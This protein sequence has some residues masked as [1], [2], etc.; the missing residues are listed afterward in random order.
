MPHRVPPKVVVARRLCDVLTEYE[1]VFDPSSCQPLLSA[2]AM[3]TGLIQ[4]RLA[5][6]NGI[7]GTFSISSFSLQG[8]FQY[9]WYLASR[10]CNNWKEP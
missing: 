3:H 9:E 2:N 5:Q 4:V 6:E 1:A 8:K 10:S 7:S